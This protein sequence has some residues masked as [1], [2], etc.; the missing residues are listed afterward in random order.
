MN[1]K[2]IELKLLSFLELNDGWNNGQCSSITQDSV[3]IAIAIIRE[4]NFP[5]NKYSFIEAFPTEDG[6]VNL[7]FTFKNDENSFDSL[8]YIIESEEI[9]SQ[10]HESNNL[11]RDC[12]SIELKE[13]P[14]KVETFYK[15]MIEEQDK[16][17]HT[18]DYYI[19]NI[20]H[21]KEG[22]L[23]PKKYSIS[24]N[25]QEIKNTSRLYLSQMKNVQ[26]INLVQY[27]LSSNQTLPIKQQ[28]QNHMSIGSYQKNCCQLF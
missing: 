2:D 26:E 12:N 17:C 21:M 23:F 5:S 19:V 9:I 7:M 8:G 6:Y 1:K 13:I 16:K 24:E 14:T 10:Y 25:F 4:V 27:A 3:L 22:P 15:K 18:L 28:Y 11:V 20:T